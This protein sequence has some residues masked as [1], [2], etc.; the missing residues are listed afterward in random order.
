MAKRSVF[1]VGGGPGAMRKTQIEFVSANPEEAAAIF[2]PYSPV[3]KPEQL[4][5]ML[6]SHTHDHHPVGTDLRQEIAAYVTELKAISV[7]K[8]STDAGRLS[9]KVYANVLS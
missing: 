1:L 6:R 7:I 4:A 8:S 3:A 5:A 9:D 2:A